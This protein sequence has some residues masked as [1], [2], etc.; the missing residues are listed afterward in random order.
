VL[1]A[2]TLG[3]RNRGRLLFGYGKTVIV[4]AFDGID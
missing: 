3:V 1:A 4:I 2:F